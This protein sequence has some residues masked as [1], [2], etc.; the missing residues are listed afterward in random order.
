MPYWQVL[1]S[2]QGRIPRSTLWLKFYLPASL[3]YLISWFLDVQL[4][5]SFQPGNVGVIYLAFSILAIGPTLAVNVKRAHDRGRSG[6]FILL[7]LVPLLNIWPAVELAFLRGTMGPNQYGP[8]PLAAPVPDEAQAV[9]AT[10]VA[11]QALAARYDWKPLAVLAVVLVAA[12]GALL[13]QFLPRGK[14]GKETAPT[15]AAKP[16]AVTATAPKPAVPKPAA[17]APEQAKAPAP[18]AAKP[19]S[20]TAEYLQ[21]GLKEKDPQK[22][23]ALYTKAIELDPKHAMAFNNRGFAYYTQKDYDRALI[24]YGQ[25]IALNPNLALAYNNRGDVYYQR[26]AY[27]RARA[28]YTKAIELKPDYDLAYHNRGLAYYEQKDYDQAIADFDKAI[29]LKANFATAYNGRGNAF[30][31]KREFDPAINDYN[32]AA[33]LS[34]NWA[35]P[36]ANRG[37]AWFE[38]KDFDQALKDY[39]LAVAKNP[40]YAWG[41]YRRAVIYNQKGD[42]E[43]ARQNYTKAK[44]LN[45]ALPELAIK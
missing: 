37:N 6:W 30:F 13:W 40:N 9:G 31:R 43:Q 5:T 15:P 33:E 22:K 45:P 18:P 20:T 17:S 38:K 19:P 23:I 2:F 25:A 4:G 11:E 8:D 44:A 16:P 29:S 24:D 28:D 10:G 1:F 3:G 41:Y 35:V 14:S 34:P 7:F 21:L 42:G 36:Y 12:A 26:K 32:K 27:D 39:D